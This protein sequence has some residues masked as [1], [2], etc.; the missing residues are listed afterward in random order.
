[1]DLN[2]VKQIPTVKTP[3]QATIQTG[4]P[5]RVSPL[6]LEGWEQNEVGTIRIISFLERRSCRPLPRVR[7]SPTNIFFSELVKPFLINCDGF[8]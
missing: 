3:R 6:E 2:M 5:Y 7:G 1:M 4:I 8:S